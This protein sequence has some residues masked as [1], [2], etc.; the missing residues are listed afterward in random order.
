MCFK[1][2]VV[3]KPD[4]NIRHLLKCDDLDILFADF[5][6]WIFLGRYLNI[7]SSWH[8]HIQAHL[9]NTGFVR[10]YACAAE[11]LL[12]LLMYVRMQS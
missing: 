3:P 9:R 4:K 10:G 12:L 1:D 11:P 2:L 7:L 8:M 6:V 5:D